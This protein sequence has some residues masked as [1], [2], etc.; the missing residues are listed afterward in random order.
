MWLPSRPFDRTSL[1]SNTWLCDTGVAPTG[2]QGQ[3]LGV[4]AAKKEGSVLTAFCT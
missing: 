4:T 3:L 1:L 2:H